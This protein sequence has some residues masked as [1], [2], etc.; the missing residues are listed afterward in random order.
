VTIKIAQSIDG[1][2]ADRRGESRWIT[3]EMSRRNVHERRAAAGAV[4]VGAGTVAKDD[5]LLSSRGTNGRRRKRQPLRVVLSGNLS[6]PATAKMFRSAR[7]HPVVVF[8]TDRAAGRLRRKAAALERRG[9]R[10]IGLPGNSRV[11]L[12]AA[13]RRLATM[14]VTSVIA[15]GGPGVWAQLLKEQLAEKLLVYVSPSIIGGINAAQGIG[16]L[17]LRRRIRIERPVVGRAGEDVVISG[18]IVR[19]RPSGPE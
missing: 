1:S 12:R 2:I 3:G 5:P 13:L 14:G 8:T 9:V 4:L 7:K 11:N 6:V 19:Q 18:V 15:E 16:S 17:P 10:V